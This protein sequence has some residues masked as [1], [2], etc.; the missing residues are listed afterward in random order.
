MNKPFRRLISVTAVAVA[1]AAVLVA[2]AVAAKAGP[3]KSE[4]SPGGTLR[5]GWENDFGFTSG[6]DP[7]GEYLGDAWGI[8]TNLLV[9]ALVGYNHVA[10]SAGNKVVP[11]L[12]RSLPK[13]TR[14]GTRYTFRLKSGLN[15]APP[16]NRAIT[17]RD[18]SYALHR[19]ARP[20][21]GG[22][23]GFYY[24]PIKGWTAYSE[25]KA[26]AISGIKTPTRNTIIFDLTAPTGDFMNR[27][28]MPATAPIPVEVAK[29]FEG[30]ATAYGRNLVATGPYMFEGSDQVNAS[31][32]SS[33]KPAS[34]FDGKSK[35]ILVRNPNYKAATDSKAAR[36]NYPDKFEFLINANVDD[37]HA[38]IEAGDYDI[39]TSSIPPQTLRKYATNSS[40]RQYFHQNSGDRTWYLTMNLTQAP[41]DDVRVR[42]AMNWIM[43]K[44]ALVQAWG[45]PT[46]GKVANHIAPDPLLG[47]LLSEYAPYKTAGDRGNLAKAKA[48]LRGSKYDTGKNGLCSAKECKEVLLIADTRSVDEKMLPVITSSAKKIGITF[49][50]RTVE[51]AYPTIQTPSNNVPI[52]E[53][54]GWGKDYSDP[55]TFFSPL[56]DGRT[57]IASGNTNYSL[58]GITP[59]TAAELKVKGNVRNVPNINAD[60]D[61]C[62]KLT[63]GARTACYAR[64]DRK[65]MT[66]VVPWVPYLWQYVTRITSKNVTKYEFDQFSSTPAYAHMAV[67]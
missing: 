11:D 23:Y 32:C 45:G 17:S 54:P 29:C 25:G 30:K 34:G 7:T 52:A 56:F 47:N 24:T 3:A 64:I 58:V 20:K 66:Q 57:I 22:Q 42:R 60:L 65:L 12:A 41:F 1:A 16:V 5:V 53:R 39:A 13:P 59:K 46:I 33:L 43:D 15:F 50:V 51:G 36:E 4:V 38:K 49:T 44:H 6:F 61:R 21:N 62:S 8:Y 48:A 35:M 19:L 28:A 9:R 63:G 55:F 10:G 18:I 26:K 40:L 14:G 31:S 2:A 67:N 37:I 27:L